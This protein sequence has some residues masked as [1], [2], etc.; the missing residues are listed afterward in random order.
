MS[1]ALRAY[2]VKETAISIVINSV[3]SAFFVWLMF[4]G[5]TQVPLW[6]VGNLA[7]D[8]V[9]QTFMISLMSVLVPSALTRKRRRAGAVGS[10]EPVLSWLPRNLPLRALLAAVG[11]VLLFASLGT[12]LLAAL[13]PDPLPMAS[14]WP[15]KIVYGALVAVIVTPLA[16]CVTLGEEDRK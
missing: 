6:G 15:M 2:V 16:L 14:V 13:A 1:P 11:G 9:P 4:G 7:F 10:C 8:F 3:L 12:L 5:R